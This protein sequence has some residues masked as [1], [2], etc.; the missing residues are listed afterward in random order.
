[1]FICL[2]LMGH[3]CRLS[4]LGSLPAALSMRRAFDSLADL[5]NS[6]EGCYRHSGRTSVIPTLILSYAYTET[7][8]L[9][10]KGR[11]VGEILNNSKVNQHLKEIIF[12]GKGGARHP[13]PFISAHVFVY[14]PRFP[15]PL[16][17]FWIRPWTVT[18]I[19]Q[20]PSMMLYRP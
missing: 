10:R 1:M 6:R 5:G 20:R 7:N 19:D 2:C 18:M 15:C 11:T 14:I 16:Q 13:P 9:S 17:A 4:R 8:T 3:T 12:S